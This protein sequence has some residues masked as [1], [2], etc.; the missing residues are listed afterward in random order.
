VHT[1]PLWNEARLATPLSRARL[2][3]GKALGAV[4]FLD[5]DLTQEAV[6][7]ILVQDGLT[8]S[9]IEGDRL[10]PASVCSSVARHYGAVDGR[11]A[12]LVEKDCLQ[13]TGKGGRSAGYEIRWSCS[14][15]TLTP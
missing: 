10:D 6:A 11:F 9:A 14:I 12:D 13:P 4:R 15:A 8:T 7:A 2:A 3:Q 1:P 5:A